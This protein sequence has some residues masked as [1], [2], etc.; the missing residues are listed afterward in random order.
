M[1]RLLILCALL[2]PSAAAH[3][4]VICDGDLTL[5]DGTAALTL[6]ITPRDL[7]LAIGHDGA[8]RTHGELRAALP[9]VRAYLVA[10][11]ALSS[12]GDPRPPEGFAWLDDLDAVQPVGAGLP[13]RLA[14]A[15]TWSGVSGSPRLHSRLFADQA[16][17]S[18]LQLRVHAPSGASQDMVQSQAT[19]PLEPFSDPSGTHG[20]TPHEPM[21]R[22]LARFAAIGVTHIVPFGFDHILFVVG[23]A[24]AARRLRTLLVH[25][26][27]FTVAHSLTLAGALAGRLP[28]Q[29]WLDGH[30]WLVEALIAASIVVVAVENLARDR[31]SRW[32]WLVIF[33]FGL[34]HGLGFAGALR[35]LGWP[36]GGFACA[37]IGFNLG[38]EIGQLLVV[39]AFV[40]CTAWFWGRDW[41]R[42][43]VIVP[44]SVLVA[45]IG[46][47]WTVQRLLS[48]G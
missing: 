8:W 35:G 43:R 24:L 9:A 31:P 16:V 6:R 13:D 19:L 34:V 26:T 2:L 28:G 23:L 47:S 18:L 33:A 14:F 32:R 27:A 12:P 21:W 3:V 11:L 22:M 36:D 38:V 4:T 17:M 39:A 20:P 1:L 44:A 46:A 40:L 30:P 29:Q 15:L 48:S 41:Y 25:V 10:H 7:A 37:V 5:L 42:A 45:A